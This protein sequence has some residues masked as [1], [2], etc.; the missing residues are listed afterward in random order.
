M[1][2]DALIDAIETYK[3]RPKALTP[4]MIAL[5]TK[6]DPGLGARVRGSHRAAVLADTVAGVMKQALGSVHAR[7]AQ[8]ETDNAALRD[9]V[10]ELEATSAAR[11]EPVP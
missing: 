9:R 7:L 5:I 8:V 4:A 10:L 3:L 1:S 2:D 11:R 6:A